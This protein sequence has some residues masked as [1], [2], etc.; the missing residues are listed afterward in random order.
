[1]FFVALFVTYC[2]GFVN[3]ENI[4]IQEMHHILRMPTLVELLCL[5]IMRYWTDKTKHM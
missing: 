3:A 1:M 5:T 2:K 4:E